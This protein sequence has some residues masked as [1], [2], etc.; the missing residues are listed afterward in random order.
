M[1]PAKVK[2]GVSEISSS[3]LKLPSCPAANISAPVRIN[4]LL[5]IAEECFI[6]IPKTNN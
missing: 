5:P 6:L 3:V 2:T 4:V 1:A